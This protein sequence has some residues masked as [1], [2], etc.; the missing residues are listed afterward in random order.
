MEDIFTRVI[1]L[2]GIHNFRDY[3]GYS[4]IGG[5]HVVRGK[6]FRSAQHLDATTDDLAVVGTLDLA[7]VIDLRGGRERAAAP[8]PR[9]ANFKATVIS[10]DAETASLAPHLE[11]AV[12]ESTA[13]AMHARMIGVYKAIAFRTELTRLITRYFAALADTNGGSLIHCLAG[14][15]RTGIAVAL[16]QHVLGVHRDDMMADYLLTNTVG[17]AEARIA[18]GIRSLNATHAQGLSDAALRVV[19]AVQPEYL[20]TAFAEIDSRH[21]SIDAYVRDVLGVDDARR[22]AIKAR[23]LE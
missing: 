17:N 19:M 12:G 21:G 20:E 14:K 7:T 10:T 5:G 8:C 6:L 3:G 13:A 18:A 22:A 9:P 1:P 4:V 15:D 23:L 2:T 11:A 16:V